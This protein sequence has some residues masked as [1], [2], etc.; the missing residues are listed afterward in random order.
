MYTHQ[1]VL[2]YD[3]ACYEWSFDGR[4]VQPIKEG[5]AGGAGG[6]ERGGDI[7]QPRTWLENRKHGFEEGKGGR[8]GVVGKEEEGKAMKGNLESRNVQQSTPDTNLEGEKTCVGCRKAPPSPFTMRCSGSWGCQ[9]ELVDCPLMETPSPDPR[10][11][12]TSAR[13]S[14]EVAE[15]VELA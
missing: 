11:P 2:G 9:P 8:R 3:L 4:H 14:A 12:C 1:T 5:L 7:L 15:V 6:G 10:Q 13:S